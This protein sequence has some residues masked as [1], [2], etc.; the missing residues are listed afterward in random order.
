MLLPAMTS[1]VD[2]QLSRELGLLPAEGPVASSTV[3]PLPTASAF[4]LEQL[5][6]SRVL[7]ARLA[8]RH[9]IKRLFHERG[10]SYPAA[11]IFLR[12]F[13]R[14]RSLELWVRPTDDTRF[15]LLKTYDICAM[16]GELGP[17]RKQGDNQT[18]EGFY[19]ISYFNPRSDYY[20]SLHIDYPNRRDRAAG[21]DGV[22]LGGDIFIHGGCLSEGCLAI[23]DEGIRELYWL[24]VEARSVGQ[25][26]IPVHIFPARLG[27]A[28]LELLQRAFSARP[29]L[30]RFWATLKAGYDY[31]EEH[32]RIPAI[33]VNGNAEYA[34]L[35]AAADLSGPMGEPV[36]EPSPAPAMAQPRNASPARAPLGTPVGGGN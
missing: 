15:E 20:L 6:H 31:F 9:T 13:K 34:V 8:T 29:E 4:A 17:K 22:K 21:A 2:G 28:D 27:A 18:P 14:E 35:G 36:S 23:T 24:A 12:I 16:A 19:A 11:E 7:E 5:R 10:I 32:R 26:R 1:H 3:V 25:R 30:G 33:A